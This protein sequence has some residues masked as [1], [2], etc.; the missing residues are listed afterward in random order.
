[1]S[2][3]DTFGREPAATPA[4][5]APWCSPREHIHEDDGDTETCLSAP[6]LLDFGRRAVA[7]D[8]V[9]QA[10]LSLSRTSEGDTLT[11]MAGLGLSL[12]LDQ[13]RPLAMALLAFDALANLGDLD[14]F[15]F[16]TGEAQNGAAR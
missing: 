6:L 11:V 13:I 8:A 5:H 7:E 12:Q 4:G 15:V 1:M 2:I 3:T 10:V 14:A 9:D 16:Y